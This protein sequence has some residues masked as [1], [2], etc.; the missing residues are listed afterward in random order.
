LAPGPKKVR[1]AT[2]VVKRMNGTMAN[3]TTK[4]EVPTTAG[5]LRRYGPGHRHFQLLL[6]RLLCRLI[7]RLRCR[8]LCLLL[9]LRAPPFP[10]AARRRQ[11]QRN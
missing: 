11:A 10:H 8:L 4:V 7:L 5:M 1:N 3:E 6:R 9:T 2:S